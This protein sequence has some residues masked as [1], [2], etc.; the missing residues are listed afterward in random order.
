MKRIAIFGLAALMAA[1]C[2]S[3]KGAQINAKIDGAA[4]SEVVNAI[5]Q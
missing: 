5:S 2:S 3:N 4:N 1:S